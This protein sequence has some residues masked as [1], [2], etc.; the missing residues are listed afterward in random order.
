ME[1]WHSV[2]L[3]S[4]PNILGSASAGDSQSVWNI[5]SL[6]GESF[7]HYT[8]ATGF[9]CAK[10]IIHGMDIITEQANCSIASSCVIWWDID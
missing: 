1:L 9:A 8:V 10:V 4:F 3:W 2:V 6:R 5:N 7:K